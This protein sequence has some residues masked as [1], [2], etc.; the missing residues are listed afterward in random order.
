[1]AHLVLVVLAGALGEGCLHP[2]RFSFFEAGAFCAGVEWVV[3]RDPRLFAS[4]GG[5][6][7][8]RRPPLD[9]FATVPVACWRCSAQG[10]LQHRRRRSPSH[11]YERVQSL[12][13][14]STN[15]RRNSFQKLPA[16]L[17]GTHCVAAR[18]GDAHLKSEREGGGRGLLSLA[19]AFRRTQESILAFSPLPPGSGYGAR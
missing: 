2:A 4:I 19:S 10:L 9:A 7:G 1:M 17:T 6:Q 3:L 14:E 12:V 18:Q 16:G 13:W 15:E 11:L 5:A 8:L